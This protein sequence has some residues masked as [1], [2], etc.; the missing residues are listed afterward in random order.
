MFILLVTHIKYTSKKKRS[1][2][3]QYTVNMQAEA[4]E[5]AAMDVL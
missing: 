3:H 1:S 5:A 2:V 4:V